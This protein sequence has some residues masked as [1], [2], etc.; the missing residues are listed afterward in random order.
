MFSILLITSTKF[1]IGFLN[2]C[3]YYIKI[4]FCLSNLP[5]PLPR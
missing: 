2:F 4:T 1:F 3:I 5:N